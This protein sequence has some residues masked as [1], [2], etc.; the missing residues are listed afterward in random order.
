MNLHRWLAVLLVVLPLSGCAEM[1]SGQGQ[2]PYAP[3]SH[4]DDG[5]VVR[6]DMM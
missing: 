2:A 3:Y 6:P 4:D 1:A 5:K